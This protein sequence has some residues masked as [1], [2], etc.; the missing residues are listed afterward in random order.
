MVSP[1]A[2]ASLQVNRIAW[3]PYLPAEHTAAR[4]VALS[5]PP[6]ARD[7]RQAAPRP[8]G[9]DSAVAEPLLPPGG[10]LEVGPRSAFASAPRRVPTLDLCESSMSPEEAEAHMLQ[11]EKVVTELYSVLTQLNE[12]LALAKTET[13]VSSC[14]GRPFLLPGARG[15]LGAWPVPHFAP[16]DPT[17][18]VLL[19][20]S[21]GTPSCPAHARP[22]LL[23]VALNAPPLARAGR[24]GRCRQVRSRRGLPPCP[25]VGVATNTP[26]LAV[27]ARGPFVKHRHLHV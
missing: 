26:A 11:C 9:G 25:A 15:L 13:W 2:F 14:G 8:L 21:H 17:S 1:A 20:T 22:A 12:Q 3:G 4:L 5:T 24:D 19:L 23:A 6:G 18:A 10:D 16:A 27:Q 7:E